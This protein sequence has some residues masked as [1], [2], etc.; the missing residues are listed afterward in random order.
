M[1]NKIEKLSIVFLLWV[2][3]FM[4]F[5]LGSYKARSEMLQKHSFAELSDVIDIMVSEHMVAIELQQ[6]MAA[7]KHD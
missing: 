6:Q 2:L 5:H 7:V 3:S 1:N 4:S